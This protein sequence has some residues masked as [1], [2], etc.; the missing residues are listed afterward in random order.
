MRHTWQQYHQPQALDE[1]LELI[2]QHG[3]D[4]RVVAGGTDVV[5]ELSRD[6]KP[7]TTLIDITRVPEL[8]GIR[9]G[10]D[11]I[12][13]GGLTTHNEV[14]ANAAVQAH[15][16]P[17]AQACIE[18]GA[19]QLRARATVA[20]N[21]VTASP[22]NDTLSALLALDASLVLVS[23]RGERVVPVSAFFTGYR[24]TVLQ[25]D[26]LIR[27][28]RVPKLTD[29]QRGIFLKLGL[30]RAQAI[31]VIHLAVVLT[32]DGDLVSDA[33]V[34]L[35]CF[36]PTVV[37][38]RTVEQWL[39][40]RPLDEATIRHAGELAREDVAPISDLRGSAD[41]R[42]ATLERLLGHALARLAAGEE[43]MGW[44]EWPILLE[45]A[46]EPMALRATTPFSTE[47]QTTING[48][49]RMLPAEAAT[50]TLLDALRE[51]AHL[52][53]AKEGCA[54]G[55]CGAC[56][57]WIDGQA[58]MSCIVPAPQV[59]GRAVT[60]IEG[61]SRANSWEPGEGSALHPLQQAFIDAAAV[62]CGF[63]IP[64]MLMAG[65]KLLEERPQP[66]MDEVQSALSGNICRCTGYRKIFDA[67]A[68]A[69]QAVAHDAVPAG[70][71]E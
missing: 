39:I 19:P 21:L 12:V 26:E 10:G 1:A 64:G 30:R 2:R 48:N 5:V 42:L 7:T 33:R 8:R 61:L 46:P 31:S 22:A 44:P 28:I 60:T 15:A 20:G 56:T 38:G 29:Q 24:Q 4:A 67:I 59:H 35:G 9:D 6:V 55:E 58:V 27:Q 49:A 40:G 53:G 11:A 54:E 45:T 37:R 47:I 57:V 50:K 71:G 63:C 65:A 3:A 25:R 36:A 69:S 17:L 51:D 23:A 70:G 14:L 41:Y 13:L 68:M 43:R 52:T 32:L 18:I 34:A 66:S 16:L 62:Q